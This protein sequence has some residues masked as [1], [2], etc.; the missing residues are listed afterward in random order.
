MSKDIILPKKDKEGNYYLSY[1]QLSTW[2]RSK[3]DYIRQYFFDEKFTGNAYTEFGSKVGEALEN[4]DYSKFTDKEQK[5]MESV[6]RYD[7]FEREIRWALDGFYMKGYIDTNT[8]P[9][10]KIADY[11]TGDIVK[12]SEEY[13]SDGYTQLDIYAGAI[14]QE[15]GKLPKDVKVILI[16]RSGNAFRNEELKLTCEYKALKRKVSMKRINQVKSECQ[17]VA[18]EISDCYKAYLKLL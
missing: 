6:P 7:Q 4:N 10:T 13:L 3:R 16:G 12:K 2:K 8:N 5:F 17:K 15:T 1:S 9:P 18:E 14:K 11:K